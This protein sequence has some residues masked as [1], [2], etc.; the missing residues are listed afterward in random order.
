[1]ALIKCPECGREVSDRAGNC[2]QCGFP[3]SSLRT[4]G[5][6]TIKIAN[7]LAGTVRVLDM[8]NSSV[9]WSGRSGQIARFSI[10]K[11]TTIGIIFALM[12]KPEK[13]LTAEVRAGGRYEMAW[14]D[15]FFVGGYTINEVDV[16]DSGR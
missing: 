5:I 14:R 11:P 2:P 12:N 6:V 13:G 16:I 1:M 7:G 10:E 15:G 4:D 3:L 9:L 8:S